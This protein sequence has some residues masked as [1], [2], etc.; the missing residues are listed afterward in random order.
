MHKTLKDTRQNQT[1]VGA[2]S[3][4][5]CQDKGGSRHKQQIIYYQAEKKKAGLSNTWGEKTT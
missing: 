5:S 1:D 3:I 4:D 2:P